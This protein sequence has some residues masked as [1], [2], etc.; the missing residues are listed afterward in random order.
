MGYFP[1]TSQRNKIENLSEVF[2][3]RMAIPKTRFD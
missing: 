3:E 2:R 1:K